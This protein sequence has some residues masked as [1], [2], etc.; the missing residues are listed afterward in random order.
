MTEDL[1]DHTA[2]VIGV[3]AGGAGHAAALTAAHAG[4]SVLMVERGADPGGTTVLSGGTAWIPNNSL[5][6]AHGLSDPKEDCLRELH[7]NGPGR[8]GVPN[9][10]MA[11]LAPEG[12]YLAAI[13][14]ADGFDTNG[15]PRINAQ[16][17]VLDLA[18]DPIPGLYGAG[19]CVASIAG[20]AYWGPGGTIGPALTYGH[21]AGIHAAQEPAKAPVG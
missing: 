19:N 15:G 20:Q 2:D 9:P 4:A 3:G 12:P 6:R 17:Q 21:I 1:F 7:W 8:G 16:A 11:P 14:G 10:T 13:V 5:M 18:G